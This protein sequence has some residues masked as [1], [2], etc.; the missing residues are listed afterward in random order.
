M[1]DV[2]NAYLEAAETAVG[3]V[4]ADR[5]AAAWDRPSSLDDM[6]VGA[7]A[8]HLAR[9]VLQVEW[10][11]DGEI[12]GT[13]T[14]SATTYYARITDAPDAD[15]DLNRGDARAARRRHGPVP[16]PSRRTL[17]KHSPASTVACPQSH[18]GAPSRSS[19]DRAKR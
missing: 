16:P 18:A 8:A 4:A 5:V 6:T 7:L 13:P 1:P 17:P 15:S 19:T 2:R 10:F 3:L 11:L 12:A 9:S 14:V